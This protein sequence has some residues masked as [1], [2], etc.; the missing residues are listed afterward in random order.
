MWVFQE[1]QPF[2]QSGLL[3]LNS[4]RVTFPLYCMYSW[5]ILVTDVDK[6]GPNDTVGQITVLL[7]SLLAL[8]FV[9]RPSLRTPGNTPGVHNKFRPVQLSKKTVRWT[10]IQQCYL[11]T[12]SPLKEYRGRGLPRSIQNGKAMEMRGNQGIQMKLGNGKHFLL[13]MQKEV[14]ANEAIRK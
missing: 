8:I 9:D 3:L 13:G 1:T 2:D 14:E 6:V 11:R 4:A 5:F 7:A 10:E 12:Y